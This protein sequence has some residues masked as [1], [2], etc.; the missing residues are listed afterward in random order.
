MH[1]SPAN[2][3][4]NKIF[5][6]ANVLLEIVLNRKHAEVAQKYL[7]DSIGELYIS[8]LTGH[9]V[10]HFGQQIVSPLVLKQFLTDFTM[11]PLDAVSFAW[12]FTHLEGSSFEDAVQVGT[13]VIG[14]CT[15]FV[16][17][18]RSLVKR[19]APQVVLSIDFLP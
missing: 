12:A 16:T 19:Y 6:D 7:E 4:T 10:T 8:A 2:T 5:L 1:Q 15:H 17:F 11:L 13:A 3:A 18:D 14:S 9:L